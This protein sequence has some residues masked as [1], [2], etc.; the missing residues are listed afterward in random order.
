MFEPAVIPLEAY[1]N[2]VFRVKLTVSKDGNLL[3]LTDFRI[4]MQVRAK[5]GDPQVL[6]EASTDGPTTD[7]SIITI[8]SA[9]GGIFEVFFT[10]TD[11]SDISIPTAQG[12]STILAYD[13][14]FTNPSN[15]DFMPFIKGQFKIYEG[16][17]E[18]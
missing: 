16:I 18:Q 17:T 6:A 8:I 13:I 4:K 11:L 12:D 1:R 7:G 9:A 2:G 5:A 10:H 14:L 15:N 3:D